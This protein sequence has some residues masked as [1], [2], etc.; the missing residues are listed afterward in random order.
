MISR[1]EFR[2]LTKDTNIK[3]YIDGHTFCSKMDSVI[4]SATSVCIKKNGKEMYIP[5]EA[6]KLLIIED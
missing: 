4:V 5:F 1:D 2:E 3:I 6:I